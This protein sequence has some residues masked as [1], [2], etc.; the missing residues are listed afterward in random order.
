ML[1]R[2]RAAMA[3]TPLTGENLEPVDPVTISIGLATGPEH[4]N[5]GEELIKLA[6]AALYQSKWAGRDRLTVHTP[7]ILE[8]TAPE[9]VAA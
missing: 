1:E 4:G 7:G 3:R 5:D 6:D 8:Q 2:V 9:R